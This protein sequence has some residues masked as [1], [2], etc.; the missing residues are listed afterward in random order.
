M[1][2]RVRGRRG[3]R[4]KLLRPG[5]PGRVAD[6]RRLSPR[7]SHR[8]P[9]SAPGCPAVW[10]AL[11]AVFA[12]LAQRPHQPEESRL[13]ALL[14]DHRGPRLV[15]VA[16]H[17]VPR[18]VRMVVG[19]GRRADLI[20]EA[21]QG[22]A[23]DANVAVHADVAIHSFCVTLDHKVSYP[24]VRSEVPCV[25]QLDA[26]VR[27]C[28]HLALFADALLEY[29][30]KEEVGEDDDALRTEPEAAIQAVRNVW[31]C[32]ADVGT[33]DDGAR[34]ALVEE[35][36][37]LMEVRV[38]VR[39]GGAAPYYQDGRLLLLLFGNDGG[40]PL[41]HQFEKLGPYTESATVGKVH[42]GVVDLLT[43][44]GRG[45]VVLG[46]ARGQEHQGYGGDASCPVL[47]E[48]VHAF[49]DGWAGEFDEA[50]LDHQ[51]RVSSAH[52][53]GQ[54]VKLSR[55]TR[56]AAAVAHDQEGRM[57]FVSVSFHLVRYFHRLPHVIPPRSKQVRS[58]RPQRPRNRP[59][60]RGSSRRA[61]RCP[62]VRP[63]IRRRPRTR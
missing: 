63:S 22:N 18:L 50:S 27:R 42:P 30:G 8:A 9:P 16:V 4:R 62:E 23:V 35:A 58:V 56:V 59:S 14:L 15:M 25:A 12:P 47:G 37:Y 26:G 29:A 32:H 52:E 53:V 38:G 51:G 46:V 2:R 61:G 45:N 33:L 60:A 1:R 43:H 54:V 10:R 19:R 24:L 6:T 31:R 17:V 49:R 36:G 11:G 5:S 13:R 57:W 7:A 34:A 21:G 39:V 3:P 40:D 44:Q 48:T 28:E 20:L 55:P 41:V